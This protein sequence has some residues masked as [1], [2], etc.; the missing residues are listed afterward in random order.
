MGNEPDVQHT[1]GEIAVAH[2]A[3]TVHAAMVCQNLWK[4]ANMSYSVGDIVTV[5]VPAF[6]RRSDDFLH[7]ISRVISV[8][9]K[10]LYKLGCGNGVTRL[11]YPPNNPEAVAPEIEAQYRDI[12]PAR[13]SACVISLTVVARLVSTGL[14]R[15]VLCKCQV[16]R[17][18]GHC[19]C[20]KAQ[21]RCTKHCH[22]SSRRDCHNFCK[23]AVNLAASLPSE[24][25][26]GLERWVLS[27]NIGA[28]SDS[29]YL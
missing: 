15:E 17:T 20:L 8:L 4:H 11:L 14:P 18:T 13:G 21:V 19:S 1:K 9:H 23:I 29:C 26:N 22:G 5:A 12:I 2:H 7:F 28:I 16:H 27:A 3:P 24:G 25:V 6:H 10:N